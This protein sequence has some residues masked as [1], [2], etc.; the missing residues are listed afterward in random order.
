MQ[1]SNKRLFYGRA[2]V[3]HVVEVS[4]NY[5]CFDILLQFVQLSYPVSIYFLPDFSRRRPIFEFYSDV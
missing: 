5:F 4:V 2:F 1:L 3:E